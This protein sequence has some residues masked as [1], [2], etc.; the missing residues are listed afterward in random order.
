MTR[1]P[2][3]RPV[4]DAWHACACPCCGYDVQV[5]AG[6][7]RTERRGSF[8]CPECGHVIRLRWLQANDRPLLCERVPGLLAIVVL[9]LDLFRLL[10]PGAH[11][12]ARK[13]GRPCRRGRPIMVLAALSFWLA[14]AAV[15]CALS[16]IVAHVGYGDSFLV[17]PHDP[18]D[19]SAGAD[20]WLADY[21]RSEPHGLAAVLAFAA[22]FAV[23]PWVLAAA[24]RLAVARRARGAGLD[25]MQTARQTVLAFSPC[26][27]VVA[28]SAIATVL[29]MSF[30]SALP[31]LEW[32][33]P[34]LNG[35][36]LPCAIGLFFLWLGVLGYLEG[37]PAR[38]TRYL[39]CGSV[40]ALAWVG[41]F[42]LLGGVLAARNLGQL[43]HLLRIW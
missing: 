24:L 42:M 6:I 35:L 26:V 13:Q 23:A 1:A 32:D 31:Y 22:A 29:A 11:I 10:W 28:A 38:V 8:T 27:C 9:P 21:F 17:A 7:A 5:Q 20:V 19:P 18:L 36:A 34:A 12:R 4:A 33:E 14:L 30:E 40:S 2:I 25:S 43:V 15:L 39:A 41:C 16:S 3:L 37:G